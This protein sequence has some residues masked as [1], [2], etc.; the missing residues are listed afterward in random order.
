MFRA[1][2]TRKIEEKNRTTNDRRA[3]EFQV[4]F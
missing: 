4:M 2:Y 1:D 3:S